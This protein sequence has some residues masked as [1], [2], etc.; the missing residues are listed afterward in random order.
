MMYVGAVGM[1]CPIGLTGG[2][3]CAALR[4]GIS[5]LQE[6]PYWDCQG[7][8]VVG[9]IVS[10]LSDC[11]LDARLIELLAGALRD[12]LSL[13]PQ[14]SWLDVP[15]IVAAPEP[16]RP[17]GGPRFASQVLPAVQR[18]L[19]VEF[20]PTLSRV[21]PR[22]RAAGFEGLHAARDLLASRRVPA[23]LVCGADS[24]INASSLHWL[25]NNSILKREGHMDGIIPGEA[26]A[27]V[28]VDSLRSAKSRVQVVGLGLGREKATL[29]GEEPLLG[30]GLAEAAKA[31]LREAGWG[32]HEIDL[33][34]SDV[35]GDT[36]GFREHTLAE[37]RL[38][39]R[40]R[41]E[42]QPLWHAAECIGDTGAA[43]GLVQLAWVTAAM[44][45]GYAPGPRALC[46]TSSLGEERAVAAVSGTDSF[47]REGGAGHGM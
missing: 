19:G 38:V 33:R 6:L 30:R 29:L 12:C 21:L 45:R 3:G 13:H 41:K 2:A 39:S 25:D 37:A 20:H 7:A 8:P 14:G 15:V 16:T 9:A 4:A 5:R 26:A 18:A 11:H 24:Y 42:P 46:F 10:G 32:Y 34:L 23:C 36:Y 1:V 22:G 27:A 40:V 35:A 44:Q 28:L 31:A 17:G 47:R 43:A